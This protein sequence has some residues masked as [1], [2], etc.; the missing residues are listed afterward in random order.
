MDVKNIKGHLSDH[1]K[2][3]ATKAELVAECD[4]LSD[5]SDEDKT[6][7]KETLPEGNYNNADEV[8]AALGMKDEEQAGAMA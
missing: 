1:Q 8:A 5:F 4:G 3:P 2:Y 6:W 7:F